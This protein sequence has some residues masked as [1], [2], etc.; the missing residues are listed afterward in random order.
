MKNDSGGPVGIIKNLSY[1]SNSLTR[2]VVE[3]I[4]LSLQLQREIPTN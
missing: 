4:G 3:G 1:A 2:F